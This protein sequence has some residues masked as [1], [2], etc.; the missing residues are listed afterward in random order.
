MSH[1]T[2]DEMLEAAE[3]P[4]VVA[5]ANGQGPW[6]HLNTCSVCRR[7][8]DALAAVLREA[9]SLEVPE[10]SPLFWGQFSRRVSEAIQEQ[11]DGKR[12]VGAS[13]GS[14]GWAAL[15]GNWRLALPALGLALVFTLVA[16]ALLTRAPRGTTAEGPSAGP[17]ARSTTAD[18]AV[19][20]VTPATAP[21]EGSDEE[22]WALLSD[23]VAEAQ[24]E[25]EAVWLSSAPGT[26]EQAVLNMSDEERV[27][28]G[29]LLQAEIDR[30]RR[31]GEG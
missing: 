5:K 17:A 24:D 21:M 31:R 22:S 23:L 18:G 10:P 6:A 2:R 11:R 1:L 27:E 8:V 12:E 19:A 4:G 28:L 26:A 30:A 25:D 3:R 16:V 14:V 13:R 7:E 20:A 29:R 15:L 9:A